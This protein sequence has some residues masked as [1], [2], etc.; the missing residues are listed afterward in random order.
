M[1]EWLGDYSFSIALTAF[2]LAAGASFLAIESNDLIASDKWIKS[3]LSQIH[4][5]ETRVLVKELLIDHTGQQ[6]KILTRSNFKEI[7][8]KAWANIRAARQN[9]ALADI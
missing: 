8:H 1:I 3:K 4:D 7:H 9:A 2:F 6:G 5:D